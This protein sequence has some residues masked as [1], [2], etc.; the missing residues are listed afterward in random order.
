MRPSGNSLKILLALAVL[1][2]TGINQARATHLRAGEIIVTR[3][4]CQSLTFT[5]TV[6]VYTN[7]GSSVLFGGRV[8]EEDILEFGD[9][10]WELVPETPN[11]PRPDLGPNIGTASYTTTHTYSGPGEY[12]ISYREPNRNQG[13]LNMD[14]SVN[15]RFYIETKIFID[16]FLG[17]NNTP[18][19]L[20]PPIDQACTGVT[21]TH[22]PG[23]SDPD[24]D[25]LSY[26]LVVPFSDRNLQVVR[27]QDPSVNEPRQFYTN[28]GTANEAGDAE[29]TFNIDPVEG[30]LTWDAPGQQGEYNIAFIIIE[31]RRI[32]NE[33]VKIGYVRRDMQILVN[34]CDNERPDLIIPE[35]VCVEAGTTLS[36]TIFGIDPENHPVKIE[37]FSEIFSFPP[38]NSPAT[39]TPAPDFRPSDPPY[40]LHFEWNT[41]C[42]HIKEQPYLVVF[43]IT[44]NPG[45]DGPRLVTFKTWR[46]TVVGPKPVWETA[47]LNPND[48]SV[49]LDWEDYLCPNA[50]NIQIWRRVD[51]NPYDPANCETGMPP[52][53]GY[54]LID[55]V[56]AS[57]VSNYLDNNGGAGLAP[58]AKYCYRLVAD[59]PSP[60]AGES[61]MSEE[62]CVGPIL[63][64]APVITHVTVDET[65]QADGVITINWRE[66]FEAD[67]VQFP[68]PYTYKVLRG[69]GFTGPPTTEITGLISGLTFTDTGLNTENLVYNYAI[70]G[71]DS[72]DGVM[73]TSAVASSVRVEARS[74]LQRI[75]LSWSAFVP[76]S[77]TS[78]QFPLHLIYRGTEGQSGDEMELIAS[79]DVTVNGFVYADQGQFN[80]VPLQDNQTY[81]YRILT[82]GTYGNPQIAEPL[83][84]FSQIICTQP[85]DTI[86]PCQVSLPVAVNAPDCENYTGGCGVNVFSNRIEWQRPIEGECQNDIDSYNIYVS[87]TL[88]G[89]FVLHAT[90]I[91]DLFFEDT[92]LA[93]NARCYKVAAVDRSGNEGPLSESVC[94]D[95]CPY[96]ELP[97]I[98]TPNGDK[99]N[100]LFSA[101]HDRPI[102]D[103]GEEGDQC[104]I[105]PQESRLKCAR[106]V[107][108]VVF[109]VYNRWGKEVY[110]YESGGERTIYIDWDG[111]DENGKELSSGVYFFVAEVIF[112]TIDPAKRNQT[113]KGWVHILR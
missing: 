106:F 30:T 105:I 20:V 18:V 6:T 101:Y 58:G 40:E 9:T 34:E 66:P 50:E 96:Y 109:K 108:K 81:C 110:S 43:K 62:I 71:Y 3:N 13:V 97:N 39:F 38:A 98:F 7:T 90:G 15:T 80:G 11:T 31:W 94:I 16:P 21:F 28:Y 25:S 76:W 47:T 107:D 78:P 104:S 102:D 88:G 91:R 72:N 52:F 44:D 2:L 45:N 85:S 112:L 77:N 24:G 5:I 111:R 54:E 10:Q 19:L 51:S 27:Y 1:G 56:P 46:I 113:I 12:V 73:D 8:G 95:N 75:D 33:W 63:A 92:N 49:T 67:P 57:G 22:N 32:G 59:F 100:D 48:R 89:E 26:Q 82:R 79:V 70:V 93:S 84:N 14:N 41:T 68:P 23:A 69:D 17:C 103:A 87:A 61:Y 60:K 35:D 42:H 65:S 4:N 86:P 99:C 64:D 83:E 37:A 74:E 36:E 29:P 53:L 55:E